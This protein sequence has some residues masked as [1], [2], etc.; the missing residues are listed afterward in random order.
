MRIL[1][2]NDDGVYSPGIAALAQ[3]ASRF[4][5]VRIV[6]PDVEMS[7]A[8]HSI[9]AS[10]PLTYKRTP[11]PGRPRGLSRER[12]AGRLRD[13]RHHAVGKGRPRALGHQPRHQPRQRH[14]AFGHAR[15][16]QA[17]RAARPARHRA[18]ARRPPT[19]SS[20]T[21]TCSSRGRRR[22]SK[23]CSRF[24]TC[25]LVNVNFP[26]KAPRGTRWTRQSVRHYDGKVVPA[27]DPMGRTHY[28]Y[29][30]V[31]V[32]AHRGRHRP[33]GDRAGLR[34]DDAAAPGPHRRGSARSAAQ[35]RR[36][37]AA[38][39]RV[40]LSMVRIGISGWRYEP[41]R[42]VFY[43]EGLAAAARARVLRRGIS[44]RSRST[45]RSIRCS[46]R[47]TTRQWYARDA[48]R[49]SSSRSR[50]RA[51]SRTCCGSRI[52]RSRSPT[53]S[54]RAFSTC[55]RQ[56][57]PVPL[58]IPADVPLQARAPRGLLPL[59]AARHRSRRSRSRARRDARM[60]GRS[61]AR[62]RRESPA[63]PRGRDPPPE[64]HERR[65]RRAAAQAPHRAGGR[66]HRG[67]SGPS[68]STSRPTSSMCACTATRRSTPAA[69]RSVRS[70]SGR[71]AS[72][73]GIAA[74]GC[75]RLLRQ[76]RESQ[77]ALRRP[78]SCA[79]WAWAGPKRPRRRGCPKLR[80]ACCARRNPSGRGP[81]PWAKTSAGT[82]AAAVRPGHHL[83]LVQTAF[84]RAVEER[85][86]P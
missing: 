85:R 39:V 1:I 72:A 6:A 28:W 52:S 16:R 43:P 19:A 49:A 27:K 8:S 37:E 58:A 34:L 48:A 47:S 77:G 79:S 7:S 40:A 66:R 18:S 57:R 24:P 81:A 75:V 22:C 23:C 20:P 46:G 13:A 62:D 14:L 70:T 36:L 11:L 32:E 78:T 64:L 69:I 35:A 42:G 80:D 56:A 30:V 50:A 76:R 9:T 38:Q 2:T 21:S 15:R 10:R 29:T 44:R 67:A 65:V 53:S 51:T 12:H 86:A 45:A 60:T 61:R 33:L 63:A 73:S 82:S 3:V 4:G 71:G 41:W 54:P 25:A 74:R 84:E 31:P 59:A 5:D 55:K 17:G 68:C 26:G 83:E